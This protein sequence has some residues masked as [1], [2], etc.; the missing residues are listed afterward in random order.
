M[1]SY[2]RFEGYPFV[3]ISRVPIH[4]HLLFFQIWHRL[5]LSA[6]AH[7]TNRF[8]M[9]IVCASRVRGHQAHRANVECQPE[10]GMAKSA[11]LC[12]FCMAHSTASSHMMHQFWA[13]PSCGIC[14]RV[15]LAKSQSPAC[16]FLA[17]QRLQL[18]RHSSGTRT[19][20]QHHGRQFP[21]PG[22]IWPYPMWQAANRSVW[23]S[24][25]SSGLEERSSHLTAQ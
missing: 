8:T 4:K 1:M 3:P 18:R 6:L 13:L 9:L 23:L 17:R 16:S 10:V 22:V 2:K 11:W 7:R 21:L 19:V 14:R 5:L 12:H 15:Q 25:Q 24:L 20:K